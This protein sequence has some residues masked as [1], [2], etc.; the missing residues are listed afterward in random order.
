MRTLPT[1]GRDA[2]A[3]LQTCIDNSLPTIRPQFTGARPGIL[4]AF[5]AYLQHR[6]WDP[7]TPYDVSDI[8][9]A[10]RDAA[11]LSYP[12]TY[13]GRPLAGLRKDIL[14]MAD[15]ICPYCRLETATTLDHFLPKS[16]N[17]V[18][19]CYAPNLAP[20]CRVCNTHKGT[21]GS[22]VAQQFFTHAYLDDLPWDV[23]FLIAQVAVG[24]KH[25]A[26]NFIIDFSVALD[27]SL[28]QRL[29]YQMSIF[30]LA[31]RYQL[32][33]VDVIF[34]QAEKLRDMERDECTA[35]ARQ[36]SIEGDS[37]SEQRTFGANHWKTALLKALASNADFFDQGYKKAL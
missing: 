26:T 11:R 18:F 37:A 24:A 30:R 28:Y 33:A 14:G 7:N 3:D 23:P 6:G 17:G 5:D 4:A 34:E 22:A 31:P 10:V 27:D 25:I 1:P 20:M 12:L 13:K 35:E 29:V 32:A 9:A 21:K 8:P 16:T 36:L 2:E 15:G 19:A